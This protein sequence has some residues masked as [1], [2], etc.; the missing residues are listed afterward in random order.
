MKRIRKIIFW[1]HLPIGLLGGLIIFV[2]CV[3]GV[4]LAYEKQITAWA[5]TRNFATPNVASGTQRLA[6]EELATKARAARNT[7]PSAVTI[8]SNPAA[9]AEV[10]F[11]RE[12]TLFLNPYSGEV[13]GEGSRGVRNFFRVV[14]DWHR[15]LGAQG[16]NR[17][18]A[19]AI[20]GACNL[21][22]LILVMSGFYLWW[23][24]RLSLKYIRNIIWFKRGLPG[25]ARDFNWHNVIGFWSV[26][27]LFIVVLSGVVI[28]YTWA[29]N[30]VYRVAG[31]KPPAARGNQP[32]PNA[33]PAKGVSLTNLN[34]YWTSAE[35]QIPDWQSITLQLPPTT[36]APV[37]FSIDSGNGGQPQKRAQLTIDRKTG[38]V[39]RFEPFAAQTR[40]R[41]WRTILRFAH[42][43]EVAGFI[44]QAIAGLASAGGIFLVWTGFALAY[45]RFRGWLRRRS[46]AT[47]SGLNRNPN[48]V[49]IAGD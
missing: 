48:A 29:S 25:K 16:E 1:C 27:P 10:S 9:P 15:W 22:F 45:R 36:E 8:R 23:P 21:G 30:L 44:G 7:D 20:T 35:Q 40:G 46:A 13:L 41:Q 14:T 31:E 33:G 12:G 42:T 2:M 43:G 37:T 5:D 19:R 4:L 6:L 49:G 34:Q 32:P 38:N 39:D 18:L 11:G 47:N 17:A 28:S 24:Q 3:T 26:V